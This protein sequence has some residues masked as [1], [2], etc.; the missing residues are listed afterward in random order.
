[1]GDEKEP[2]VQRRFGNYRVLALLGQVGGTRI[3]RA[4][5]ET[6]DRLVTLKVLPRQE[7]EKPAFRMRFERQLAAAS[8]L[9]HPNILSALDAGSIAG[10]QYIAFE[11]VGGVRLAAMLEEGEWFSVRRATT[12]AL[13]LARALEHV[14][15]A[16]MLHRSVNPRC[17]LMDRSGIPKLRGFSFARP[18]R[19]R[20]G[21][22]HF[23]LDDSTAHY[24]AHY[25]SPDS[26]AHDQLDA[27][28]D[29]YSLGCILYEM[30]TGRPPFAET[31][32]VV[33]LER[34][35]N[36][37]VPDPRELCKD[38]T[39]SLANVLA[40]ALQKDREKRYATPSEMVADLE[41]VLAGRDVSPPP[42][43]RKWR[44]KR[45]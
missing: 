7:S 34:H 40:K 11:H 21:E 24:G 3:Y 22:T 15:A 30:L 45:R 17:I 43:A 27:R 19:E 31:S 36:A 39:D 38:L 26:I 10:H 2:A 14:E 13:G 25:R 28:A 42:K 8:K 29:I 1:M 32:A 5:Q 6:V 20:A 35:A 44:R 18:R 41:A 12:I 16:G 33:I 23:D 9:R 37:P 4:H